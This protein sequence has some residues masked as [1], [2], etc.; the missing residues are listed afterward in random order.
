MEKIGGKVFILIGYT[1]MGKSTLLKRALQN[2]PEGSWKVY[3]VNGEYHFNEDG[4]P[5]D[6]P[7]MK[8]FLLWCRKQRRKVIAFEDASAFFSNRGYNDIMVKLLVQKRHSENVYFLLFHS[9]RAVP[10]YIL[11]YVNVAYLFHT[12][13]TRGYVEQKYPRFLP[14]YDKVQ[15]K[16]YV[17]E[18]IV[19]A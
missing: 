8:P 18:K 11:D 2:V 13:D 7:D 10:N 12:N 16:K 4:T 9:V 6:L 15:G 14:A 5:E 17:Y 3:D 1:G 19:L